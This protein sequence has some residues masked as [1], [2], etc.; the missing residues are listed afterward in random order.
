[1]NLREEPLAVSGKTR[2]F[3]T[4]SVQSLEKEYPPTG[5]LVWSVF[6]SRLKLKGLNNGLQDPFS[7]FG[8]FVLRA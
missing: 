7:F 5:L 1:M 8:C 3:H 4:D 2:T 6:L